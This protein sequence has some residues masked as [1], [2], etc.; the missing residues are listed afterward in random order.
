MTK[1]LFVVLSALLVSSS[2][3]GVSAVPQP[4]DYVEI[5]DVYVQ[6]ALLSGEE[7]VGSVVEISTEAQLAAFRDEVNAGQHVGVTALL[8]QDITLSG[9]WTPIGTASN[10]FNGH[11][12]GQGHSISGLEITQ[13][14]TYVGLFGNMELGSI[15]NVELIEPE[16]NITGVVDTSVTGVEVYFGCLLGRGI[17]S[18]GANSLTLNNITISGGSIDVDSD[19]GQLIYAGGVAGRVETLSYAKLDVSDCASS[20]DV[21]I[22]MPNKGAHAGLVLGEYRLASDNSVIT[23]CV[24]QGDVNVYARN[25]ANAGLIVGYCVAHGPYAGA[26]LEGKDATLSGID[27]Y[28]IITNCI[29]S[30]NTYASA[31][32]DSYAGHIA[33]HFNAYA[34]AENSYYASSGV[35][36]AVKIDTNG[37]VTSAGTIT[38]AGTQIDASSF[39]DASFVKDTLKFD[40]QNTWKIHPTALPKLYT[41]E[42]VPGDY[43]GNGIV[44]IF[45]AVRIAQAISNTAFTGLTQ[46]QISASDVNNDGKVDA[47][48]ANSL[49][50]SLSQA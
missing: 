27:D 35:S 49:V 37:T 11:F 9:E 14:N 18:G 20:M 42:P 3:T 45:D 21:Y 6:S 29:A 50:Q 32:M 13:W 15:K 22:N 31:K 40:T 41:F 46:D 23:N 2:F 34:V 33:G 25:S 24:A 36:T 47:G 19:G 8:T 1:K 16:I 7:T 4:I 44:N 5:P 43:D 28:V 17:V 39:S 26:S 48:D 38:S 10:P 12:D 30:G